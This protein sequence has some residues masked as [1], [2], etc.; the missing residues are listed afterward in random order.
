LF[1]A[2]IATLAVAIGGN[3]TVFSWIEGVVLRP[4]AGVPDQHEIVAVAGIQQPG[5]R[6]CVF[7]YPDY[8][9]YR[10]G[11]SVLDGLIAG[12]LISPTFNA[13]GRVERVVGQIVTGNYFDVLRVRPQL[14]RAFSSKDDRLPM[15]SPVV[16]ISDGFWRRWFGGDPAVIGRTIAL[17]RLPFTIIGVAPPLFIGTFVGYS[18]DLWTPTAMEQVFFPGGDRR[19]DRRQP[20]LEGYARLKRGVTREEAQA[21]LDVI[22]RRIQRQFPDTH[23]GFSLKAFPLWKTPYGGLPLVSPMLGVAAVVVGAVFLIACANVAGLLLTR[24]IHRRREMAVRLSLGAT[25]ARLVRQILTESCVY[26]GAGGALGLLFPLYFRNALPYFFPSSNVRITMDGR[27]DWRVL[28]VT[29]VVTCVT[30]LLFGLWPA[31]RGLSSNTI[32]AI[33]D[34]S[35]TASEG[36]GGRIRRLFLTVQIALTVVL[37]VGAGLFLQTLWRAVRADLGVD[38]N[39]VLVASFDLFQG[40]YDDAR[41][42]VFLRRLVA[43]SRQMPGVLSAS[44]AMRLPFSVRGPVTAAIE[45]PG[46]THD[47]DDV[48][49][50]EYNL[51]GPDYA[52]TI[53]LPLLSGRD[54][55][56][57]DQQESTPVAIVNQ[58]MARRYWA[59]QDPLGRRFSILG[60]SVQIVGVARDGFYHSLAEPARPYVYLPIQQV[61]QPQATMV[62][63]TAGDPDGMVQRL[64]VI[65]GRVD[66][67][68]PLYSAMPMSAYLGFAVVGQRTA[69]VLLGIFGTLALFLASLGLYNAVAYAVASRRREIGIRMALGG[70]RMDIV[71]LLLR[72]GTA[73]ILAGIGSGLIAAGALAR[74]VTTQVYGVSATDPITY[75]AAALAVGSTAFLATLLPAIRATRADPTTALRYD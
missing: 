75:G 15:A 53:G 41:G 36:S 13:D 37:L 50:A 17:N 69:A 23:R 5:D 74:F 22:S 27:M 30:G 8:V 57:T 59:G 72:G 63:R 55:S 12:E 40:G 42:R 10:D 56:E 47:A 6:C 70:L 14:G 49:F 32:T 52:R 26:A 7:S 31:V 33:K 16:V 38:R 58:T 71:S 34:A 18:L 35:P 21:E 28:L 24:A 9:D 60:K 48:P 61:Y 64:Q 68:L 25:R 1:A 44:V 54:I 67:A 51:V 43:E 73:V 3:A 65:V 11:N 62:I 39:H 19:R 66:P 29:F 46:Y 45:V 4:M 2:I 20:W